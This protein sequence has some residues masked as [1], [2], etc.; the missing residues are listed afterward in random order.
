MINEGINWQSKRIIHDLIKQAIKENILENEIESWVTDRY[1]ELQR[2]EIRNQLTG[3]LKIGL[4]S[5]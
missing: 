3:L 5:E 1:L 4:E 2:A